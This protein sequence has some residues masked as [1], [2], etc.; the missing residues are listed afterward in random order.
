MNNTPVEKYQ[1]RV[2]NKLKKIFEDVKMDHQIGGYK[3]YGYSPRLDIAIQPYYRCPEYLF[4]K[5]QDIIDSFKYF[6]DK[7]LR[8]NDCLFSPSKLIINKKASSLIAIEIENQVGQ[9]HSLGSLLNVSL[10]GKIGILIG[11]KVEKMKSIIQQI[12][13]LKYKENINKAFN[14]V[15]ILSPGQ[16][17]KCITWYYNYYA[18]THPYYR[19]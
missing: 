8:E 2:A 15:L 4:T 3:T 9:K 19:C 11:W 6:N 10:N 17:E 14:N 12:K 1:N 5:H 7:N 18:Q 13:S 16:F